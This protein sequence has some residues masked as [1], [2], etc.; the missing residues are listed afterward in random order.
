MQK[1]QLYQQHI[2]DGTL[3]LR[4]LVV[5]VE[6]WAVDQWVW[7][8]EDLTWEAAQEEA[9]VWEYHAHW[10]M[11]AALEWQC[12]ELLEQQLATQNCP[13]ESVP[14]PHPLPNPPP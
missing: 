2:Q 14:M 12:M 9:Q 6:G 8:A 5:A 11:V 10:A 7:W 13:G 1:H 4:Q 3:L